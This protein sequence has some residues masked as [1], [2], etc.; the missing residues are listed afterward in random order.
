MKIS[1]VSPEHL[2]IILLIAL[3]IAGYHHDSILAVL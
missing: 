2:K 3:V 1:D